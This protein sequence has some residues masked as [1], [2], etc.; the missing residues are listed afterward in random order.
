MD[1]EEGQS[2]VCRT[3]QPCGRMGQRRSEKAGEESEQIPMFLIQKVG[4]TFYYGNLQTYPRWRDQCNKPS[5]TLPPTTVNVELVWLIS[6]DF[7][8]L[9]PSPVPG[10]FQS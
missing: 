9:H 7:P 2:V 6:T 5:C 1:E 8:T 10:V 3:P 4:K